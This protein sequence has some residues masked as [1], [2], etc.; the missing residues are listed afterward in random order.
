[1]KYLLFIAISFFSLTGVFSQVGINT[2]HPDES[3]VLDISSTDKGVLFP[4]MDLGDLS[5]ADPVV[6]PE[7][8]LIVWNTDAAN[9]GAAKGFYYWDN[10]WKPFGTASNSSDELSGVFGKLTLDSN[11]NLNLRR[12]NNTTINS[13]SSGTSSGVRLNDNRYKMRVEI[14]GRYRVV[15]SV[16]YKKDNNVG[17]DDIEFYFHE[18]SNA[19]NDSKI[20]GTLSTT[21]TTVTNTV[22]LDLR[23]NQNYGIGFSKSDEAPNSVPLTIYSDLTEFSIQRL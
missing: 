22:E 1:M 18:N 2:Q 15:Y 23:A 13:S 19:I 20:I 6:N 7:T 3:A 5:V 8:S 10:E 14:D 16:T 11:I 4:R 17:A 21:K 12:Y 9:G